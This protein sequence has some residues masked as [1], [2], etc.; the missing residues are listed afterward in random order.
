MTTGNDDMRAEPWMDHEEK[1]PSNALQL[2]REVATWPRYGSIGTDLVIAIPRQ[3]ITVE[4]QLLI[5]HALRA[6]DK[7][8]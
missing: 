3:Q 6:Y 4:Q 8:E 7:D 5:E 2:A 1:R